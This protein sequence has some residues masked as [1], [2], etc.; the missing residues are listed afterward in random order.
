MQQWEYF[1]TVLES[2]VAVTP[3]PIRDD[4]PAL[5]HPK[6]SSYTLIPRLN[7]LGRVG[8]ELISMEP[9]VLGRNGDTCHPNGAGSTGWARNYQ[10]TFKRPVPQ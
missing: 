8:W 6:Y 1:T 4:I 5:E 10:C 3:V 2:N 9:V 7:Q